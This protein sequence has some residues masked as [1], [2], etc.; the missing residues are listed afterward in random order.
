MDGFY[1][2][3]KRTQ[4]CQ[5]LMKLSATKK[6]D[7]EESDFNDWNVRK[8]HLSEKSHFQKKI[9]FSKEDQFFAN[10]LFPQEI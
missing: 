6:E 8:H 1:N 10:I 2:L 7:G 5:F 9:I 3:T 4:Q